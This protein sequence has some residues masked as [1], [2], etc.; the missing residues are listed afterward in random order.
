MRFFNYVQNKFSESE[1]ISNDPEW[2]KSFY[3]IPLMKQLLFISL[4]AF[5]FIIACK[6][7]KKIEASINQVGVGIEQNGMRI[8]PADGIVRLD[9]KAF[10][11]VLDFPKPMAVLV[12]T[13]FNEELLSLASN[14]K[15]LTTRTEFQEGNTMAVSLFN[16]EQTIYM[17]DEASSPFYYENEEEHN[18]NNI[19]VENNRYRCT[20]TIK[21]FQEKTSEKIKIEKIDA[22]IFLVFVPAEIHESNPD[23]MRI[24]AKYLKIEWNETS[25]STPI[26]AMLDEQQVVDAS[27]ITE[28]ARLADAGSSN[29]QEE[30][31]DSSLIK[32]VVAQLEV[33]FESVDKE[34]ITSVKNPEN[35]KETI[36]LIP[37]IIEEY[38]GDFELSTYLV[39]VDNET[40]NI[41]TSYFEPYSLQSDA[42]ML[43]EV[44][45]DTTAYMIAED[46]RAFGI[47]V[48][49][50]SMS[51][52]NPYNSTVL[53]LYANLEEDLKEI[54]R[55]YTVS[56]FSGEGDAYCSGEFVG[57][58]KTLTIS[59]NQTNRCYDILVRN[60]ITK[61]ITFETNDG[62]CDGK[63]EITFEE[64]ILKFN[65]ESYLEVGEYS[66]L[67]VFLYNANENDTRIR[68]VPNGEAIFNFNE[69][70]YY[71]LEITETNNGWSKVTK[72]IDVDEGE[73][74]NTRG[75]GWIKNAY[76]G[77]T[78]RKRIALLDAPEHGDTVGT[79]DSETSVQVLDRSMDWVLIE[80]EGISG[81][82]E[83]EWL[84]GNPVT[85]CP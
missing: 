42:I 44:T 48:S 8:M 10:N 5:F 79:I 31:Q 52:P 40:E 6:S 50:R 56:E 61:T 45:I 64:T 20:Q 4:S 57:H 72:V 71:I 35:P 18:F 29:S 9:K 78:T 22:P 14:E 58:Q 82:I 63:D 37:V 26:D 13:S 83:S 75:E 12:N 33:D 73:L 68:N 7:S 49:H 85:T 1:R 54:L 28:D 27:L 25:P 43:E 11:V 30:G 24:Q 69:D 80:G 23:S 55:D 38:D 66:P 32:N 41:I 46:T 21:Y 16:T 84:C 53:S 47:K 76:I 36:I 81:W 15:Q 59:T 51:Q 77:A 70:S 60:E 34:F 67:N 39:I 74:E 2:H 17:S 3:P 19:E 65:G 62:D